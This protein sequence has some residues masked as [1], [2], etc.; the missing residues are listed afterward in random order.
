[1]ANH[2][3][4][5]DQEQLD[6][7]KHFWSVYGS[8]ITWAVLL[9]AGAYIAWNGY[10]YYKRSQSS[11]AA[12]LFD[13]LQR[14]A[15]A[16]DIGRAQAAASRLQTKFSGTAY[17]QQ[18]ALA[19][20]KAQYQDN[21]PEDTRRELEWVVEHAMDPGYKAVARLR[22]AGV[23]L[24]SKAYDDAMKVLAS[25]I[26]PSFEALAADRRGDI[27]AVQGQRDKAATAYRTAWLGLPASDPYR[28]VVGM[29]L[30][31]AGVDPATLSVSL[32]SA[33]TPAKAVP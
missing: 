24:E 7:L 25:G 23:L 26:P 2:L 27:Y 15:N 9:V 21:K 8:L 22:L 6:Q 30:N 13:E 16:K 5:E 18:G 4:L 3:D 14:N 12:V 29:K 32:A 28:R 17:A 33:G 31:A 19:A 11:Q 10:N 20:A 1:M